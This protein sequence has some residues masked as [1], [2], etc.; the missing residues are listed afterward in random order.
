MAS[1][2]LSRTS[3]RKS[4]G[5][6]W[7]CPQGAFAFPTFAFPLNYPKQ[8]EMTHI[9]RPLRRNFAFNFGWSTPLLYFWPTRSTAHAGIDMACAHSLSHLGRYQYEIRMVA[10]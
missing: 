6:G 7:S 3:F 5:R 9:P 8:I 1:V 4:L 10:L 2:A